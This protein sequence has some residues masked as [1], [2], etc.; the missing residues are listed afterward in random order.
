MHTAARH[1][2]QTHTH[3]TF[4]Q[5]FLTGSVVKCKYIL[6]PLRRF[7]H[8]LRMPLPPQIPHPPDPHPLLDPHPS[9]VHTLLRP[10]PSQPAHAAPQVPTPRSAATPCVLSWSLCVPFHNPCLTLMIGMRALGMISTRSILTR[11]SL[12]TWFKMRRS[13]MATVL[14]SEGSYPAQWGWGTE[15]GGVVSST[16][17]TCGATAAVRDTAP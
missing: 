15:A 17:V 13:L 4:R 16:R 8:Q 5:R 11:P 3:L 9:R 2:K 1:I 6:T 14:R 12:C 10:T 7:T